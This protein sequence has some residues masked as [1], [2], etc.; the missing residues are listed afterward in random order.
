MTPANA[1][2]FDSPSIRPTTPCRTARARR[3]SALGLLA[4]LR[5]L[6]P[7]R[8]PLLDLDVLSDHRLRD[9]GFFDGRG[10]KLPR[11]D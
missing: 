9:L 1:A 7:A 2:C 4:R 11:R 6:F 8:A 5:S 10:G 3:S